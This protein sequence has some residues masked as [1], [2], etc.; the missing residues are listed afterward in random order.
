M[1]RESIILIIIGYLLNLQ[2]ARAQQEADNWL[3]GWGAWVQFST[4]EPLVSIYGMGMSAIYGSTSLSD[5]LGNLLFYSNGQELYN[6]NHQLMPNGAGLM[7]ASYATNPCVAFPMPGGRNKYYFFTIGGTSGYPAQ[8]R[9]GSEYSVID[10]EL[11]GGYGDIVPGK[12]NIPLIAADSVYEC[13]QAVKHGSRDAYWVIMRNHR[14]PNK[15]MAFLVDETG[16]NQTPVVSPCDLNFIYGGNQGEIMKASADGKYILYADRNGTGGNLQ[17]AELYSFNNITGVVNSVLVFNTHSTINTGAEFSAN[18]DLLYMSQGHSLPAYDG[19]ERW[20]CQY[21][22]SKINNLNQFENQTY[23]IALDTNVF[24]YGNLLLANNGRIYF[25]DNESTGYELDGFLSEIR[26]PSVAGSGC[27]FIPHVVENIFSLEGLPTFVSSFMAEFTWQGACAGDSIKFDSRFNPD[28]VSYLWNFDDPA[29]GTS[30]TSNVVD[31]VHIF[32]SGGLYNVSVTVVFPNGTQQTSV[33]QVSIFDRPVIDLGDTL[34]ICQSSSQSISPGNSFTSYLWSTGAT[35]SS[36]TVTNPGKYWVTVKNQGDCESTDTLIVVTKQGIEIITDQLNVAPTTC[37]GQTGAITGLSFNGQPPYTITWTEMISG[38]SIGQTPDIYNLGV[39]F[40]QI[41]VADASG[42][43]TPLMSWQIRDVGDV[44]IDTVTSTLSSC[45]QNTGAI[46]VIAVSGLGSRIQY[47]IKN[48]SDTLMQ[49]HNGVFNGLEPGVYY[50]WAS[51]STGCTCVYGNPVMISTPDG[52]EITGQVV[53]PSN[54]GQADGAIILTAT[55]ATSDTIYYTVNGITMINNGYF[56][57]LPAGTYECIVTNEQGCSTS[58][59]LTVTPIDVQF[60]SAVAGENAV[61]LGQTARIPVDVSNFTNITSF[62]TTLIYNP[63][64]LVCT[65]YTNLIDQLANGSFLPV[66][67]P[68]QGII[69]LN[70]TGNTPVSLDEKSVICEL[71]FQSAIAGNST[72]D[73]DMSPGTYHFFNNQGN[74][75]SVIYESGEAEFNNVPIISITDLNICEKSD[76]VY[77]P[78]VSGG[79]GNIS[80]TWEMPSGTLLHEASLSLFT[81]TTDESGEYKFI[82]SDSL[83]CSD[84]SILHLTVIPPPAATFPATNPTQDT[85]PFEQSYQLEATPGY[86]SYEWNTGDTAYFITVTEEGEY[87]VIIQTA[88]GCTDTTAVMMVNTWFPVNVPNAFTPNGDGLNDVFKPVVDAEQ[89]RQFSMS[90]YNRWGQLFFE[91][92]DPS[93][94]WDGKD[95]PAGIYNWVITYSNVVGKVFKLKGSV[96]LVK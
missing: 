21:D 77:N 27:N 29:S 84:T 90:I 4:G 51:D 63:S 15:M 62:K 41:Q 18:S 66:F 80:Y 86:A 39:G 94:G 87:S 73:W 68:S 89:V 52:P 13:L 71:L 64:N 74:E 44:L 25:V 7:A 57:N 38:N 50:A 85:I 82:V 19:N 91:T 10:M 24:P 35:T 30:N 60:L 58:I 69:T 32:Q 93:K 49:W 42:C 14:Q 9:A 8:L 17:L 20:I 67:N 79:T 88:E 16:V 36:I 12:L 34:R 26:Y 54:P 3:F 59:T 28:P 53:I 83:L 1:K 40:Y 33:R 31:P 96:T 11:D 22:L 46:N 61:C 23:K 45:D 47:F 2:I 55:S 70:W 92:G 6:R 72:I 48:G 78:D 95:K 81:V 5:S 56:A 76:L 43:N 65:G 75:I 37:G